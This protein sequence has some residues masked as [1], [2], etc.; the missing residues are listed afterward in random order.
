MTSTPMD[1]VLD[2][3]FFQSNSGVPYCQ[4]FAVAPEGSRIEDVFKAGLW[5]RVADTPACKG[6]LHVDDMVG[7]RAFDRTF[8]VM[9]VVSAFRSDL[10]PVLV[11]WP[12]DPFNIASAVN[13]RLPT[14][15][16]MP[17]TLPEACQVLGVPITASADDIRRAGQAL[18]VAWHPD[19]GVD[20]ADRAARETKSQQINAA[21]ELLSGK[22]KAA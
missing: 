19:H 11:R 7:I 4:F 6:R 22:R 20:D 14:P 8:D 15:A 21:I 16:S 5:K 1:L 13:A 12:T 10:T 2:P 17:R 3:V 18:Q 9:V